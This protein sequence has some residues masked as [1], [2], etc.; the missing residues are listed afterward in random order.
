MNGI[1]LS[2]ATALYLGANAIAEVYCGTQKIWPTG[3]DYSTLYFTIENNSN[4]TVYLDTSK[5]SYEARIDGGT[6]QSY[7]S[8]SYPQ[9]EIQLNLDVLLLYL[10]TIGHT[11]HGIIT[12]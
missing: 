4:D 5:S 9:F 7:T 6:W 11:P 1:N 10:M 3:V 2:D 8:S 12:Q